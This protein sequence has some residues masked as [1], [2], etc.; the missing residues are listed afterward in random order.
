MRS[1]PDPLSGASRTTRL[2]ERRTETIGRVR[3]ATPSVPIADRLPGNSQGD[4]AAR[5]VCAASPSAPQAR[6]QQTKRLRLAAPSIVDEPIDGAASRVTG[7][8]FL[9]FELAGRPVG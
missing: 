3:V 6:S 5:R 8:A 2:G 7:W 4:A 1:R 9:P